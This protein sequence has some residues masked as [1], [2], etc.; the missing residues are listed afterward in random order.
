MNFLY[1]FD[2][3]YNSQAF[4]SMISLLDQVSENIN[5]FVIHNKENAISDLPV[6]IKNHEKLNSIKF[7][8]FK[9]NNYYFP[10][11]PGTHISAATYYRLFIE[12]YLNQDIDEITYLDAD[13][14]CLK[15]PIELLR[16]EFT[17]LVK[18]KNAISATTEII[19]SE[20]E[21]K[22][23]NEYVMPWNR[24]GIKDRYFNA[25]V[26]LISFRQWKELRY[27]EKLLS[28]L[29]TLKENIIYWDQD[30]LNSVVN[31]NYCELDKKFNL[32]DTSVQREK[33]EHVV[34]MHY[35]GKSKPWNTAYAFKDISKY[36][37]KNYRKVHSTYFHIEHNGKVNSLAYLIKAIVDGTFFDIEYKLRYLYEYIKSFIFK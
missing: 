29:Q 27:S 13:T 7:Y 21:E 6:R 19:K 36:Y 23:I 3:N 31:G 14:I 10:N 34:F 32:S 30:I 16:E 26:L 18:S 12:N 17:N 11:I 24:L 25:G 28:N 37:H 8:E 22:Y 4:S 20:I 5:I 2:E 33:V 15:D 35:S 1:S 9:D